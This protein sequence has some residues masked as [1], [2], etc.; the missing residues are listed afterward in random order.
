VGRHNHPLLGLIIPASDHHAIIQFLAFQRGPVKNPH[1]PVHA[2]LILGKIMA[3]I[4]F[5]TA[6]PERQNIV[7]FWL[8]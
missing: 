2:P 7:H 4:S 5:V 6:H 8:L 1:D 3:L